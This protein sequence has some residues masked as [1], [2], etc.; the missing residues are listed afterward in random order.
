MFYGFHFLFFMIVIFIFHFLCILY[1]FYFLFMYFLYFICFLA[2]C[3][4]LI[5]GRASNSGGLLIQV[6][7]WRASPVF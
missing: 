1:L 3:G 2:C 5:L 4:L 7:S 6:V